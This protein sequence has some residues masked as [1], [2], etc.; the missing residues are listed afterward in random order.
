MF[1]RFGNLAVEVVP[2][3][4]YGLAKKW[5]KLLEFQE[6]ISGLE[7]RRRAAERDA[8]TASAAIAEARVKDEEAASRAIR[9]GKDAPE[10]QHERKARAELEGAERTAGYLRKAVSDA[11]HDHHAYLVKHRAELLRD[12]ARA[13]EELAAEVVALAPKVA[14]RYAKLLDLEGVA[15]KLTPAPAPVESD[16][17]ARDT[18]VFIAPATTATLRGGPDRGQVEQILA[19]LGSLGTPTTTEA[20]RAETGAA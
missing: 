1:D 7:K 12:L 11:A 20:P 14:E 17:P 3:E 6:E 5:P 16:A 4:A 9:A 2:L 19:H 13:R 8:S 10:P 18:Q 15:K